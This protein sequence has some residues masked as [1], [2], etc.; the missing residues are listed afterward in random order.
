[1]RDGEDIFLCG[2]ERCRA[3]GKVWVAEMMEEKGFREEDVVDR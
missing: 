1:M 3:Y 2:S